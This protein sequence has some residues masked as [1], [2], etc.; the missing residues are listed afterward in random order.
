MSSGFENGGRS[1]PHLARPEVD[2]EQIHAR[3]IHAHDLQRIE[4]VAA[5]LDRRA[6]SAVAAGLPVHELKAVRGVPEAEVR[7][8]EDAR[9]FEGEGADVLDEGPAVRGNLLD[10]GQE[11]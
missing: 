3:E 5:K 9:A 8:S 10:L 1:G 6:L 7:G 4:R 11:G 2:L